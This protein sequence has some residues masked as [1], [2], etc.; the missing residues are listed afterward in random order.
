VPE[1]RADEYEE[2][3]RQ[4][5]DAIAEGQ[6][7]EDTAKM[8]RLLSSEPVPATGCTHRDLAGNPAHVAGCPDAPTWWEDGYDL[9]ATGNPGPYTV[10][11]IPDSPMWLVVNDAGESVLVDAEAQARHVAEALNALPVPATGNPKAIRQAL[12]D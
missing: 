3:A 9:P 12:D 1:C 11:A 8:L 4:L 5:H 7:V 6:T 2:L 10:R